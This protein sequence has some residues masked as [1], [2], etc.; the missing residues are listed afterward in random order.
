[1]QAHAVFNFEIKKAHSYYTMLRYT[2]LNV[3]SFVI[4]AAK[5]PGPTHTQLVG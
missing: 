5:T 2:A 1:L 3:T 4:S